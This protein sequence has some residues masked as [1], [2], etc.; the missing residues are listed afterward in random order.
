MTL[1][2]IVADPANGLIGLSGEQL[3]KRLAG[4]SVAPTDRDIIRK[5]FEQRPGPDGKLHLKDRKNIRLREKK[6]KEKT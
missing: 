6:A 3:V 4:W 5:M 1:Y 2:D